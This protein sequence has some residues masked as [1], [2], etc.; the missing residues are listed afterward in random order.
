[1]KITAIKSIGYQQT[2]SPEMQSKQHNYV[3]QSRAVHRNSH[4][5]AYCLMAFRCLW[6]KAHFAPE[7][8]ACV[9]SGCHPDKIPRYMSVA[10]SEGWTPTD[11][12][13]SGRIPKVKA[14]GL[15]FGTLN[16][17][18][19]TASFT[20]TDDTI[21]QGIIGVK[22]IGEKAAAIFEGEGCYNHIDAFVAPV[23]NNDNRKNKAVLERL[24]KLKVFEELPKHGNSKAL[25]MYYQ[26]AYTSDDNF[27]RELKPRVLEALGWNDKTI[28]E[29]RK[30]Q[31]SAYKSLYPKRNKI[32][33]KI[34]N[35]APKIDKTTVTLDLM[36]KLFPKDFSLAEK[37]QFQKDYFGFYIDSPLDLFEIRGNCTIQEAK[38]LGLEQREVMLE[39]MIT[40]VDYSTTKPRE[41]QTTGTT[42]AKITVTDGIQTTMIFVWKSELDNIDPNVLAPG[43]GVRIRV[44]FDRMRNTFSLCRGTTIRTLRLKDADTR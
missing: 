36:L 33:A 18:S 41:G 32:P 16:I 40:S 29:E 31:I 11:I 35:W 7:F 3:A 8:W 30:R 39:A 5:V 28:E 2:F 6:L 19:L 9:M 38:E 13:Y 12:T 44:N 34:T 26:Y 10:R 21:N 43:I 23:N 37:L 17:N 42:Y 24:I 1:M 27:R 20:A 15:K 25:W 4:S 22:G 14:A